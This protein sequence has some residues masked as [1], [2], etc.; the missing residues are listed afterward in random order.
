M[1]SG[2]RPGLQNRRMAGNPVIG[3][4]DP[5]SLPPFFNNLDGV[6]VRPQ[7]VI[8]QSAHPVVHRR[9]VLLRRESLPHDLRRRLRARTRPWSSRLCCDASVPFELKRGL[10]FRQ[11]KY[12]SYGVANASRWVPVLLGSP[13]ALGLQD[14]T[15]SGIAVQGLF[16]KF[17]R[18]GEHEIRVR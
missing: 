11:A 7:S 13:Q 3:G 10:R 17:C 6:T 5:H 16:P 12:G 18:T 15:L 2:D 1:R 8:A 4:F 9:G 14:A